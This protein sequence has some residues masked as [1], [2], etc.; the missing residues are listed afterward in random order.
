[1]ASTSPDQQVRK[2]SASGVQP[3][4]GD[5]T[6]VTTPWDSPPAMSSLSQAEGLWPLGAVFQ[7]T[8]VVSRTLPSAVPPRWRFPCPSAER[9]LGRRLSPTYCAVT[10]ILFCELPIVVVVESGVALDSLLLAQV[11]VLVFDTV[12]SGTGDLGGKVRRVGTGYPQAEAW[13]PQHRLHI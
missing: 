11:L 3:G 4:S 12:N 13:T 9:A 8:S 1:M 10:V 5:R 6:S 2:P 7:L